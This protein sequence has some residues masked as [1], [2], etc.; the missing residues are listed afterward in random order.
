VTIV[1]GACSSFTAEAR[2]GRL[3]VHGP[4]AGALRLIRRQLGWTIDEADAPV[5]LNGRATDRA[6]L[7]AGDVFGWSDHL[8]SLRLGP[9]SDSALAADRGEGSDLHRTLNPA[10]ANQL[11]VLSRVAR[12]M[13]PIVITGQTG[14][15]KE[16]VARSVHVASGRPGKFVAIN[17]AA[18][19]ESLIH[20]QLFGHRRGA[21]SG[22]THDQPGFIRESSGGTLFLDEVGELP[23]SVQAVFLRALQE[24]EVT[25]VGSTKPVKVDL[26]LV[27]ATNRPLETMVSSGHFR[28]DLY[29]RIM[30]FGLEMPSLKQRSEDIGLI[31]GNLLNRLSPEPGLVRFSLRAAMAILR[32]PWP[33][34]I[35]ELEHCLNTSLVLTADGTIGLD[36]LPRQVRDYG[37]AAALPPPRLTAETLSPSTDTLPRR[38]R[39]RPHPFT[40]E[41]HERRERLLG[42][43]ATHRGNIAAV[44]QA[45]GKARMQVHRW[46]RRYQI[47]HRAFRERA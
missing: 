12:S 31:V 42:L 39:S 5:L 27:S 7:A 30:G 25:P 37:L 29:A 24:L 38:G 22:A 33:L 3:T 19:P 9:V 18:L 46:M 13:V 26:R 17:C 41:D 1:T 8:F 2:V 20:A 44:S 14:T 43:L 4:R 47:D 32:Y 21:F 11:A 40:V 15:G 23:A 35:R 45:I 6:V 28:K 10:L 16:L 36:D 34:N